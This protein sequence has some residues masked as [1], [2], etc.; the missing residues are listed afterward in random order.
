MKTKLDEALDQL[1]KLRAECVLKQ[2]SEN[3]YSTFEKALYD[4]EILIFQHQDN[5]PVPNVEKKEEKNV[6]GV[7]KFEPCLN[8]TFGCTDECFAP[9]KQEDAGN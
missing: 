9:P 8:C 7:L 6:E 3:E 4:I 1:T 5:F 2:R